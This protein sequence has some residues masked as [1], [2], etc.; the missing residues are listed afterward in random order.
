MTDSWAERNRSAAEKELLSYW[1]ADEEGIRVNV[2]RQALHETIGT[3]DQCRSDFDEVLEA[4]REVNEFLLKWS[5]FESAGDPEIGPEPD[6]FT[7]DAAP[8]VT[9]NN[10]ILAKHNQKRSAIDEESLK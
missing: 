4:L 6:A 10:A 3:L 9:H 7:F 2:S 1:Q 8:I 5:H